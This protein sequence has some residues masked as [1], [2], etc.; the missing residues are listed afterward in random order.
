[1]DQNNVCFGEY[2]LW[3]TTKNLTLKELFVKNEKGYRLKAKNKRILSLLILL[4]S[5]ASIRRKLL[6]TTH[7]EERTSIQILKVAI[8]DTDLKKSI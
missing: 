2:S 1:M 6:K 4:I 7:T 8:F 5:V 3:V